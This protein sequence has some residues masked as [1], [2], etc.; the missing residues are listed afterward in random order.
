MHESHIGMVRCK[1][2]AQD[3]MYWPGMNGQIKDIVYEMSYLSNTVTN[4]AKLTV[5]LNA[6][7]KRS[8]T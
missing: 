2:L 1:Q 7:I 4:R 5:W 3:I 8:D 6:Q